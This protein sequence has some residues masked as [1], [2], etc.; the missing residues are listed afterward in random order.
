MN[1]DSLLRKVAMNDVLS[2]KLSERS[3]SPEGT[4]H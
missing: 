4:M 1:Y 3:F 2:L